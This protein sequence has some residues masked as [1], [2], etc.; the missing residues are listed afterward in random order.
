MY[1]NSEFILEYYGRSLSYGCTTK[2]DE[3]S[4]VDQILDA[5]YSY[6]VL[7]LLKLRS[8]ALT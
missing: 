6:L 5:S 3:Y 4:M 8:M 7:S 1:F 2:R